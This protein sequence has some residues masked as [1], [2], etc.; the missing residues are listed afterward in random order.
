METREKALE[1]KQISVSNFMVHHGAL[2]LQELVGNPHLVYLL[3]LYW[4]TWNVGQ[5]HPQLLALQ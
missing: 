4:V 2:P 3:C 5:A 1:I